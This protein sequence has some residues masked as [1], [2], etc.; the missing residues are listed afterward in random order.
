[1]SR[2]NDRKHYLETQL[3]ALAADVQ[4]V[5]SQWEG[6]RDNAP[7]DGVATRFQKMIDERKARD[8]ET[9]AHL[10]AELDRVAAELALEERQAEQQRQA[11]AQRVRSELKASYLAAGMPEAIFAQRADE[12]L[13]RHYDQAVEAAE[14]ERLEDVRRRAFDALSGGF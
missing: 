4:R 6:K 11:E 13:A 5:V 12:L 1:M 7:T 10:E 9:R 2:L 8:A 3:A 14:R